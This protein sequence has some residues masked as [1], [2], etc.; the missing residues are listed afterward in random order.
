MSGAAA[1]N[2]AR[3]AEGAR[4]RTLFKDPFSYCAH[5]H[6]VALPSGELVMVFNRA[7]RRQ[8]IL[9][10]PQEPLFYNVIARSSD[11]GDSWSAPQVV[12]G[13]DWHGVECAGLTALPDDRVLLNQWRFRWYPLDVARKLAATE[14]VAMPS[15]WGG[16]LARSSELD[17]GTALAGRA[18]ALAP[19]ARGGGD[20]YVHVSAD[21]GRTFEK[22]IRLDTTPF[23][24]GYGMR[25]AAVLPDGGLVL[26]LSDVPDYRRVFVVRSDDGG[27]SWGPAIAAAAV[28]GRQ[29][30]EPAPLALPD[31]RLLL[32]L[33][34]NVSRHLWQV[35]SD[36]AGQSWS[37]PEPTPIDGYPAHLLLLPDDRILCVYGHRK[38][39]FSIRAV[40]S[41]NGGRRWNIETT[42]TIRGALPNKDLGYAS[43]VVQA[44][45]MVLT[46][47]Y[48]QEEDG[49]T[50]IQA[51]WFRP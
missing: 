32:L 42:T 19:W 1:A 7:P 45:G 25:G 47:Y 36:D 20:A 4:Q 24:G 18:E 44:D 28:D 15:A 33:R 39:D 6:I 2:F 10:P 5:P 31:G 27:R 22:T 43:S 46:V 38:P 37:R 8:F 14:T 3:T 17:S 9:H 48:A 41:T 23:V 30:E 21:G 34:E 35:I 11:G 26:P 29:F 12:P 40:Q 49:V 13:Y 16:A 50:T 51:T